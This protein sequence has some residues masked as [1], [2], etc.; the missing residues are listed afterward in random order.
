[1]RIRKLKAIKGR[2]IVTPTAIGL[3]QAIHRAYGGLPREKQE[4]E[5]D[6]N[7]YGVSTWE[8][9]NLRENL[10]I[11]K[12]KMPLRRQEEYLMVEGNIQD[13]DK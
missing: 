8:G 4:G 5:I 7:S 6:V 10:E 12:G 3:W 9:N 11:F 2:G 13:M 1:M